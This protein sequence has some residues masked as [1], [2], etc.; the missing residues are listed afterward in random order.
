VISGIMGVLTVALAVIGPWVGANMPVIR[1][2]GFTKG[3]S[4]IGRIVAAVLTQPGLFVA[5]LLVSAAPILAAVLRV[6]GAVNIPRG[7]IWLAFAGVVGLSSLAWTRLSFRLADRKT[8]KGRFI[9]MALAYVVMGVLVLVPFLVVGLAWLNNGKDVPIAAQYALL[10]SPFSGIGTIADPFST[11]K[12]LAAVV[13][14]F[15]PYGPLLLTTVF[16]GSLNALLFLRFPR[17]TPKGR[18]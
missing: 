5:L 13:G 15:G 3:R 11:A 10:I 17:V 9:G 6:A 16:Y 2:E 4:T 7:M 1:S 18:G 8:T 12:Q 14:R